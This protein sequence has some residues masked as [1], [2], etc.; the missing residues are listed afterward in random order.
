MGQTREVKTVALAIMLMAL[1]AVGCAKAPDPGDLRAFCNLLEDGTGLTSAPEAGDLDRLALV[2]PPAV[3]ET[4]TALQSRARDFD[5]LLAEDPPDIEALFN[6]RFDPRAGN[7]RRVLAQYASD[8]CGI[9]TAETSSTRWTAFIQDEHPEAAWTV[10]VPSFVESDDGRI[11]SATLP[12]TT[13]PEPITLVEE[14][15]LAL[16][17]FLL[18]DGADPGGVR[19]QVGPVVALD[20]DTPGGLCRLP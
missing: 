1:L 10:A 13:E 20:Y 11:R 4:I 14:A 19:I 6:A 18:I 15:C 7:E 16:S 5:E 9:V 12:F 17:D 2:A 3:Q 8:S